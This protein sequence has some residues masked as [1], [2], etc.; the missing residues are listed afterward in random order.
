MRSNHGQTVLVV[1]G[2]VGEGANGGSALIMV[3]AVL[4][5]MAMLGSAY[6]QI[7]RVDRAAMSGSGKKHI[8]EVAAA[9]V[10]QIQDVLLKDLVDDGGLFFNP[11]TGVAGGG[12][13]SYDYP[14]T[15]NNNWQVTLLNG[16]PATARGGELDDSWLATTVPDFSVAS[17][18][19]WAHI[20]N[21]NGI[22][23]RIPK[24]GGGGPVRPVENV[25]DAS[26]FEQNDTG[27]EIIAQLGASSS[28]NF[29]DLG[30]DA[31]GDG[32]ED[33]RWTWAPIRQI[34]GTMYVMGVRI[35]DNS[36]LLNVNTATAMTDDGVVNWGTEPPRGY[37]PTGVD[38]TRLL[39]LEGES[40]AVWRGEVGSLLGFRGVSSTLATSLGLTNVSDPTSG[41]GGGGRVDVWFNNAR[42]YGDPVNK[43]E[44]NDELELR[45]RSGLNKHSSKHE[46]DTNLDE[47]LR[48]DSEPVSVDGDGA[49][50]QESDYHDVP[51]VSTVSDAAAMADYFQ[52]GTGANIDSRTYP[53]V[54]QMLTTLS[55]AAVY[56]ANHNGMHTT[57]TPP[58]P[59]PTLKYDLVDFHRNGGPGDYQEDMYTVHG[60]TGAPITPFVPNTLPDRI[61]E[62]EYWVRTILSINNAGVVDESN[63]YLGLD[64]ATNINTL[65]QI[66]VEY[67]L[68]IQDYSDADSV[69]SA[70]L[71]DFNGDGMKTPGE[72]TAFGLETLPFLREVYLQVG[73]TDDDLTDTGGAPFPV[74]DDYDT[75]TV[76]VG[77]QAAAIEIGNPFDRDITINLDSTRLGVNDNEINLRIEF[78]G[79]L[80]PLDETIFERDDG[81]ALND[82]TIQKVT[83]GPGDRLIIYSNPSTGVNEGGRGLDLKDTGFDQDYGLGTPTMMI[84]STADGAFT[85]GGV[86][87]TGSSTTVGLQVHTP[88]ADKAWGTGDDQFPVYD[89]LVLNG[90]DFPYTGPIAHTPTPTANHVHAQGSVARDGRNR[91]YLSNV[92]KSVLLAGVRPPPVD[93]DTMDYRFDDPVSPNDPRSQLNRDD[94]GIVGDAAL[95]SFQI[96]MANRRFFSV[97]ELGWVQMFG[98][99][100]EANGD[101]PQRLD[102]LAVNRRTLDFS[103][104]AA[105]PDTVGIPHAAMV[106]DQFTTL[107]PQND[108]VDNDND[109]VVDNAEEQFVPGT[110][111]INTVP[112]HLATLAAPLPESIVNVEA[113]MQG[114]VD[115]RDNLVNRDTVTGLSGVRSEPGIASIGELMFVN[116]SVGD[117]QP[118][119]MQRY[120]NDGG[121][122][123]D[124]VFDLYPVPEQPGSV[125]PQSAED[126]AEEAMARFQ[127]LSQV[128]T[129]RSDIFTA[130]VVI[131][132]YPADD[133][134]KGPVESLRFFAVFDRSG[135]TSS[136]HSVQM[137]GCYGLP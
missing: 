34:G 82:P 92:G 83:L 36:S 30:V 103:T 48:G 52:G 101:F 27:L 58:P 46:V 124:S 113:L 18:P 51:G 135:V 115:Y 43:L 73:F 40:L 111:N 91:R 29:E 8:D 97:A 133:F 114:V 112:L 86:P 23:V 81:T 6:I 137:V 85:F 60:G 96:P 55:G 15:S 121:D 39:K 54:R 93:G 33:S 104:G 118:S 87:L 78:N 88:G 72:P 7:A 77:S 136:N 42:M 28:G 117:D 9:V 107:S 70:M 66:A 2:A 94:K 22:Y 74:K 57:P 75:W 13:E 109:T 120:G 38:L 59:Q 129:T 110:I 71:V 25:V 10:S 123:K 90:L 116:S 24:E 68:A 19:V 64:A 95:D 61:E 26:G 53:A 102:S 35:V 4:V 20:T 67:A 45:Y 76:E 69:P 79:A 32:V 14:W 80:I 127:F 12:D 31:D 56:G 49:F 1:D 11:N 128:F 50:N 84:K 62:L 65:K 105:V 125:V 100:D 16:N 122:D 17:Q 98:F 126:G 108:T 37:F 47:L 130:Y 41:P 3:I 106:M 44:M 21:L 131:R 134:G 89:R 132:G 63:A 119:D 99:T 5:L